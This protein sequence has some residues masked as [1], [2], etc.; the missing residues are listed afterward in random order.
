MEAA[1]AGTG[2][3]IAICGAGISGL[4]LA[5]ILSR[6]WA[7]SAGGNHSI[8]VFERASRDRDQG[9]GLDLNE[10]GQEALARAGVYDRYWEISRPRSDKM[11]FMSPK[12]MVPV[13]V[14]YRPRWL[15]DLFPGHYA[16]R[17]ETNREKLR[18]I[19]L[20]VLAERG[21]TDV[22]FDTAVADIRACSN[23]DGAA[24]SA[25]LL[26][27][28]GGS[29]GRYHVV[30]DAMGLH[31]KL[32]RHRVVDPVGVH[33]EGAVLVHGMVTP[34]LSFP[35]SLMRAWEQYGTVIA[36]CDGYRLV[37]QR[38]GGGEEDHRTSINYTVARADG[39]DGIYAELGFAKPT[40][41]EGGIMRGERLAAVKRWIKRDMGQA[42]H[43]LFHDA[44]DCLERVTIRNSVVHGDSTLI[45]DL[46]LPLVCI[47][48]SARPSSFSFSPLPACFSE[49][50]VPLG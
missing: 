18:D 15:A 37:I 43:P 50:C 16:A 33:Y 40:S 38:Y 17:P 42:F 28:L 20:E 47:G 23:R 5:G 13:A 32:R 1:A 41:R 45:E 19:L 29:L 8:T 10:F 39:E 12:S 34:E 21:N 49:L 44:I 7:S 30:I 46:A 35:P 27:T 25:E 4:T 24:E 3:D 31:S 48:V 9:Y 6:A 26:D 11:A 36:S 22:R 14:S 2:P